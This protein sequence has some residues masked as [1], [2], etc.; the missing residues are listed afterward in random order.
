MLKTLKE[1]LEEMEFEEEM[2]KPITHPYVRQKRYEI[3]NYGNVLDLETKRII[4]PHDLVKNKDFM[5]VV[6]LL[7]FSDVKP[8]SKVKCLLH[9]LVAWEFCETY[10]DKMTSGVLHKDYDP[11]NNY[12]KNLQWVGCKINTT[13][14]E[15]VYRACKLRQDEQCTYSKISQITGLS[16]KQLTKLYSSNPKERNYK[17]ISS[18]FQFERQQQTF[19]YL[20]KEQRLTVQYLL[21]LN[22]TPMMICKLLHV[23]YYEKIIDII[24]HQ[25]GN[26]KKKLKSDTIPSESTDPR[27]DE[28]ANNEI[29][30]KIRLAEVRNDAKVASFVESQK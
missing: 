24:D 16:N 7:P 23:P 5:L 18:L 6:D 10:L 19:E 20:S 12:Y 21:A 26:L 8:V 11:R 27:W 14:R 4:I 25:R 15:Q 2:W 9:E 3:S 1:E 29:P 13:M 22:T 30:V 17:D 28:I